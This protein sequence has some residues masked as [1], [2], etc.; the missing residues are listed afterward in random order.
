MRLR[1]DEQ[2]YG[3]V[4]KTLHWVTVAAIAGQFAVGLTM[5][6]DE[7]ALER[8]KDRI[9]AL[10]EQGEEEA[11]R[12]G[13]AAEDRFDAEIDR[14]E[15]QLDAREDEYVADAFR[16][17]F[18]GEAPND[19]FSL[20]EIHVLLG[21]AIIFLGVL[22]VIWR[23]ATPLPPWAAYLGEGERALQSAAE[24]TLL[25][26]L[27]V[28]PGSGLLLVAAGTDFLVLHITAQLILLAAIAVH[29]GLV[30]RHT[31]LHRQGHLRR[32]L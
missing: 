31:V 17:V 24:K 29:V 2:G 14:L 30:L 8:E 6:A 20:P 3:V 23:T 9:D 12:Q 5:E 10:E 18:S 15:D 32:M 26:L 27:F 7:A 19:G 28:V 21:L 22:R 13:D 1:N 25:T 16:G 4:T 11:K